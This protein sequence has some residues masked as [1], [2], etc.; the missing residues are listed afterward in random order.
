MHKR[1]FFFLIIACCVLTRGHSATG[2][3]LAPPLVQCRHEAS[4]LPADRLRRE[5]ALTLAR[6]INTAQGTMAQQTRRYVPLAALKGLPPV[7]DG[8]ELRLYT[9]AAGYM[10]AVKDTLDSCRYAVF[11][12]QSGLL[13]EKSARQAPQIAQ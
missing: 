7:P 2:A 13:Y 5:A 1:R 6:A 10:F 4:E 3:Q 12:D 8:F 9:D 11:S